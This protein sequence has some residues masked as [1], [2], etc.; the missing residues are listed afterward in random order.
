MRNIAKAAAIAVKHATPIAA[1]IVKPVSKAFE[2]TNRAMDI[3]Q[4][5]Y[6]SRM[7]GYMG[8]GTGRQMIKMSKAM[9]AIHPVVV[10]FA[11]ADPAVKISNIVQ[12]ANK[13]PV[14]V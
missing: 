4:A 3:L 6:K 13:R 10:P 12:R 9:S 14:V 11:L 7:P 2:R 5:A 8:S 1:K